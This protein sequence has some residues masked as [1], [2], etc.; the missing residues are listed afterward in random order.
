[1]ASPATNPLV[2][3]LRR[4]PFP[5]RARARAGGAFAA[6]VPLRAA[7]GPAGG[8]RGR[9]GGGGE[10]S[11]GGVFAAGVTL[12]AARPG[13]GGARLL[14][15]VGAKRI[16]TNRARREVPPWAGGGGGVREGG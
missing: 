15:R 11:S 10:G 12:R 1:M 4:V 3:A 6:R 7:R 16:V 5:G 2:S 8:G 13:R 14:L 9:P